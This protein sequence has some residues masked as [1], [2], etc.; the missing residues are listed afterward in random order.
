MMAVHQDQV[1]PNRKH[2]RMT[3]RAFIQLPLDLDRIYASIDTQI[4]KPP[5]III[6]HLESLDN[7]R[8][9]DIDTL[10]KNRGDILSER[11]AKI[12]KAKVLRYVN[13]VLFEMVKTVLND[14]YLVGTIT[15]T[16][17]NEVS[18]CWE[19]YYDRDTRVVVNQS[20]N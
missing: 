1:D 14:T 2:V 7:G 20:V 17:Q 12:F 15:T 19:I 16:L 13:E 5:H 18:A 11:C 6:V 4:M 9:P 10:K 3:C 8:K